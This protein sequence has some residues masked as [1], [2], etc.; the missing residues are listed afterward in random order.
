MYKITLA[1]F[2]L[3]FSMILEILEKEID[4]YR[5]TIEEKTKEIAENYKNMNLEIKKFGS[6]VIYKASR[7]NG[8][9]N[10]NEFLNNDIKECQKQLRFNKC[11]FE[12]FSRLLKKILKKQNKQ[13]NILEEGIFKFT[14][15][16]AKVVCNLN[17]VSDTQ[18]LKKY[19]KKLSLLNKKFIDYASEICCNDRFCHCKKINLS[20]YRKVKN[21]VEGIL[22]ST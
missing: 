13:K 5:I 18:I 22:N 3:K 6:E 1:E 9:N 7:W 11:I 12:K 10:D 4:S 17:G 21:L 15:S 19:L 14:P 8:Y 2:V 16:I 20:D